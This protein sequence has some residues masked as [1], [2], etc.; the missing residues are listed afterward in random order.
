M[1]DLDQQSFRLLAVATF[2]FGKIMTAIEE[3]DTAGD[4]VARMAHDMAAA[5]HRNLIA[6]KREQAGGEP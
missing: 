5:A 1:S 3:G 6:M 2:W 4:T